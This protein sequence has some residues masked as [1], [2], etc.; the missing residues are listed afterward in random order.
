MSLQDAMTIS[1]HSLPED[2]AEAGTRF[3]L[4]SEMAR[5]IKRRNMFFGAITAII[6]SYFLFLHDNPTVFRAAFV[7]TASIIG[8]I[9]L[10]HFTF[11]SGVR[12]RLLKHARLELGDEKPLTTYTI[13]E[14]RLT[15]N[16]RGV[17]IGFNLSDLL[18][19]GEVGGRLELSFGSRGLCVIP[20][21]AFKTTES[22]EQFIHELRG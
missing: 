1:Y 18:S 20:L 19:V 8:G 7:V 2:V 22:K 9:A 5:R 14:G 10:N 11:E 12:S 16:S 6:V 15:C 13:Q 4:R 3:F 21:T 17:D